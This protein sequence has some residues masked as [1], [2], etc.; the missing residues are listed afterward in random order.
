MLSYEIKFVIYVTVAA[1]RQS[2][3]ELLFKEKIIQTVLFDSKHSLDTLARRRNNLSQKVFR[4]SPP[5][6]FFVFFLPHEYNM[7]F[8]AFRLLQ[9]FLQFT[10]LRSATALIMPR[11]TITR[12]QLNYPV[13]N[14]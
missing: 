6:F 1:I 14:L 7:L 12:E 3:V 9:N 5:L 11:I 10:H 8:H 13:N 2:P 4:D